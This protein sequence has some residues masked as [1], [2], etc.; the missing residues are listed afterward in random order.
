MQQFA[1]EKEWGGK[2]CSSVILGN[3]GREHMGVDQ[4]QH[5]QGGG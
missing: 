1:N 3:V 2:M 4:G 5:W